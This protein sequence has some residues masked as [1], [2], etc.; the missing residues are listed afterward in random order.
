MST[1]T[2]GK[3]GSSSGVLVSLGLI[4]GLVIGFAGGVIAGP[5]LDNADTLK[6]EPQGVRGPSNGPRDAV[7]EPVAPAGGAVPTPEAG[8]APAGEQVPPTPAPTNPAPTTPA[9]DAS[10]LAVPA[11]PAGPASAPATPTAPATPK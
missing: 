9:P 11:Q 8:T 3:K 5:L 6:V 1:G 7:P 2:Q 4:I 10:K